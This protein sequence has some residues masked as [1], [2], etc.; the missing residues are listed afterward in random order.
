MK[1]SRDGVVR[2]QW[3]Q[4]AHLEGEAGG[5]ASVR[6]STAPV[7]KGHEVYAAQWDTWL[8][9][10]SFEAAEAE[11]EN[12]AAPVDPLLVEGL[13]ALQRGTDQALARLERELTARLAGEVYGLRAKITALEDARAADQERHRDEIRGLM[14]EI[15]GHRKQAAAAAEAS[16]AELELVHNE[17]AEMRAIDRLRTSR[18]GRAH[19]AAVELRLVKKELGREKGAA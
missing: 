18:S 16:K 9:R 13:S 5:H 10:R 7:L 2:E 11:G 14:A 6:S 1:P 12:E 4:D 8:S 15:A 19:K 17:L 3:P